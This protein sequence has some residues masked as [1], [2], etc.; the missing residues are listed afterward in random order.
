MDYKTIQNIADQRL[1]L[2]NLKNPEM[3]STVDN[4]ISKYQIENSLLKRENGIEERRSNRYPILKNSGIL[5][6][7]STGTFG[8]T[9]YSELQDFKLG[10]ELGDEVQ[11]S[12][13]AKSAKTRSR[14]GQY[15]KERATK[16]RQDQSSSEIHVQ[17]EK[18]VSKSQAR[19]IY[20]KQKS[21][22]SK[23]SKKSRRSTNEIKNQLN[24]QNSIIR[25]LENDL[26]ESKDVNGQL[27]D[28]ILG[29]S[30][31]FK[32]L[33]TGST[34]KN[35][36]SSRHSKTSKMAN[37]SKSSMKQSSFIPTAR[38]K[39]SSSSNFKQRPTKR[40]Q[41]QDSFKRPSTQ[42]NKKTIKNSLRVTKDQLRHSAIWEM[43][44]ASKILDVLTNM[45]KVRCERRPVNY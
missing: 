42:R 41:F 4:L 32:S 6:R 27:S 30:K 26:K 22:R 36:Q 1:T 40:S 21:T 5:M 3:V 34:N 8:Q 7:K 33:K 43:K 9:Q 12:E 23:K 24:I 10:Q 31:I 25:K 19:S 14:V 16:L 39:F 35:K 18:S 11:N 13:Q 17:I 28:Q 2:K 45:Q 20:T 15:T 38:S 29:F 37:K 44:Q